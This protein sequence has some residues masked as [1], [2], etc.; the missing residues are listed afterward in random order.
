MFNSQENGLL[1]SIVDSHKLFTIPINHL[2][3]YNKFIN[4]NSFISN[5]PHANNY[6]NAVYELTDRLTKTYDKLE[7]EINEIIINN[8]Q[9]SIEEVIVDSKPFAKLLNFKKNKKIKQ[10]KLLI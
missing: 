6:L 9:I 5:F 4:K 8:Q 2:I 1:Y 3:T 10:Q 7:F